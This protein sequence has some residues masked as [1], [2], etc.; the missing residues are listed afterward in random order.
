MNTKIEWL[1]VLAL[2]GKVV[3]AMVLLIMG[4][5][6]EISDKT[7]VAPPIAKVGAVLLLFCSAI[8]SWWTLHSFNQKPRTNLPAWNDATVVSLLSRVSISFLKP[9]NHTASH[10]CCLC[11]SLHR[12]ADSLQCHLHVQHRLTF[13]EQS[14]RESLHECRPGNAFDRDSICERNHDPKSLGKEADVS[15]GIWSTGLIRN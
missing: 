13:Q 7:T 12:S 4:L 11:T 14:C 15:G 3:L 8:L 6:H 9:D 1:K 10:Q 2:H 5:V